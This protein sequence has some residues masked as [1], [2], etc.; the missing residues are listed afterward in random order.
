MAARVIL[1]RV[2]GAWL[3]NR[4]RL[5]YTTAARDASGAGGENRPSQPGDFL[6]SLFRTRKGGIGRR[7]RAPRDGRVYD[8]P[9][10]EKVDRREARVLPGPVFEF[11]VGSMAATLRSASEGDG[12]G[13]EE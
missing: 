13:I 2:L 6:A 12:Y 1:W 10:V 9:G 11:K 3:D 7:R 5:K 4:V 8:I